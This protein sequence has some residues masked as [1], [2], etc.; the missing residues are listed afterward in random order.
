MHIHDRG[1]KLE[2][3]ARPRARVHGAR[4]AARVVLAEAAV[5]DGRSEWERAAAGMSQ[6][7]TLPPSHHVCVCGS[8][9]WHTDPRN[10][11]FAA[12]CAICTMPATWT[13][14]RAAPRLSRDC[15]RARAHRTV[16]VFFFFLPSVACARACA[17]MRHPFWCSCVFTNALFPGLRARHVGT[18][19]LGR[20]SS[21]T[22]PSGPAGTRTQRTHARGEDRGRFGISRPCCSTPRRCARH[23]HMRRS[24]TDK[25]TLPAVGGA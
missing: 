5:G 3:G 9:C 13:C 14:S 6:R 17:R 11:C 22:Q 24:S 21:L 12:Q 20:S 10:R 1:G 8:V 7:R 16:C 15:V 23:A 19:T 2:P 18:R 4:C 25:A